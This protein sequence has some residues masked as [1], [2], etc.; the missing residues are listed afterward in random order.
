MGQ[1]TETII[2]RYSI[3]LLPAH[4]EIL[5]RYWGFDHFRPLQGDII[6]SVLQGRDTLA[7]LP[8]GRGKSI[9]YQLPSLLHGGVTLVVT[10]LVA[11]MQ[12]QVEKLI[13]LDIPA[14]YISSGMHRAEVYRILGNTAEKAY[15]L[16]YISPERIQ[17]D[18]FREF[19][20][21]LDVQLI[22][23]DEAHCVS[24]WGHDFRP[25]Y[26][27]IKTLR[28]VFKNVPV[29]AVSASA[30]RDVEADIVMQL[31]LSNVHTFTQSFERTNLQYAVQYSE[32]KN[33]DTVSWLNKAG[34]CSIIYC[35]SRKQ[36][37]L[38]SRQLQ[39]SGIDALPY[40]AGM[41]HEQRTN[42]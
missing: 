36:T 31:E 8:T 32:Q 12:E 4:V 38:L 6:N 33:R 14:A 39:Q 40:H 24:Q 7:L 2:C 26:L 5:K 41:S 34:G 11:L 17:T 20:P 10:P 3:A 27:E 29:L 13:S 18:L 25:D 28:P 16:L 37:E 9:C 42:N 22:A 19:L 15:K 35:R 23:V 30:T 1:C 21:V